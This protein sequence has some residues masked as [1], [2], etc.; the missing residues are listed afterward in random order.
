MF[1]ISFLILLFSFQNLCAQK[2]IV[3]ANHSHLYYQGRTIPQQD[4]KGLSWP[5]S[6]V[7]IT[8]KG[9]GVNAVIL[10]T[11]TADYYNIIVD[12]KVLRRIHIDTVKHSYQLV[13]GLA[14]GRHTLQ[15]FKQTESEK[16]MAVL[17]GF[18]IDGKIKRSKK[19]KRK[20]EFYGNSITCGY[21][22]DDSSG[23]DSGNGYFESNYDSYSAITARYFNAEY[24]CVAKSGIGMMISWGPLI[25]PEMYDRLMESDSSV[26]WN[27]DLYKPD[28]VVINIFQNDAWLTKRPDYPEFKRRFPGGAPIEQEII[29]SYKS[30][31][32]DIRRKYASAKI[33]CVLG[34]MDA[35]KEGSPWPGYIQQAVKQLND[36]NIFTQFFQLNNTTGHPNRKEHQLMADNLIKFIEENIEW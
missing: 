5:G 22:I 26:K 18:E 14:R 16:G 10:D 12:G 20:V 24:R 19:P 13:S 35:T 29:A 8:F 11:D 31:V 32:Q 9:T 6:S 27:F 7:T 15:L 33:I 34:S 25:M 23:K 3:S 28:V 1:R 36:R 17:S 30:F 2:N 21:A 4:A